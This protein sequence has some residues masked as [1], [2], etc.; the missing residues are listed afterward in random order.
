MFLE[1]KC[2]QGDLYVEGTRLVVGRTNSGTELH[3]DISNMTSRA[4]LSQRFA[5]SRVLEVEIFTKKAF[6]GG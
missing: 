1:E 3:E 5:K 4:K 6:A 2:R